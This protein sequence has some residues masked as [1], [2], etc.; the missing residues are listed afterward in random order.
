MQLCISLCL[1]LGI[2]V[3]LIISWLESLQISNHVQYQ[4]EVY[5]F[6]FIYL[7]FYLNLYYLQDTLS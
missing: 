6:L 3:V 5:T 2:S 7:F 4:A 1:V